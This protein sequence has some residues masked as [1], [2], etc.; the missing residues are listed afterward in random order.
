MQSYIY[1]ESG[2]LTSAQNG[3]PPSQTGGGRGRHRKG[4]RVKVMLGLWIGLGIWLGLGLGPL[5]W[6]TIAMPDQNP[7][8]S[9][10]SCRG[11]KHV[12]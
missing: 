8:K 10:N 7:T 12:L 2:G 11:S 3:K 9:K 4:P 5:R 6:W 1:W